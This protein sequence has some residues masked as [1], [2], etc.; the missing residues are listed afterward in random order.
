[1]RRGGFPDLCLWKEKAVLKDSEVHE[2]GE[3]ESKIKLIEVKGPGDRLMDK[4]KVWLDELLHLGVDVE[5]CL[6]REHPLVE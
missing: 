5:V 1:M 6:V 4:Q 2:Q 3:K